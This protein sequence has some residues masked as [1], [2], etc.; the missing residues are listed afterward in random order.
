MATKALELNVEFKEKVKDGVTG[1]FSVQP[2]E[3]GYGTTIGNA[4]R[5]VLMTAIPGA[6]ITHIKIEGVQHEFSTISGVK[7]DVADIIM[8]LKNVRFRLMDNKPD[9][10]SIK[11]KG[12]KSFTA[13]DIQ[14]ASDKYDQAEIFH[15]KGLALEPQNIHALY[16]LAHTYSKT[17]QQNEE[18]ALL[19]KIQRM[20]PGTAGP[21]L[22]LREIY[23]KQKDWK[24]VCPLQKK[25]LPLLRDKN[26]EWKKEQA[27]L[28]QFFFELGKQ[29]LQE[30]NL[31]SAISTF[32][33]ALRASEQCLPAYLS[34]GDAYLE[35]GKQKQ[36]LKIWKT[37]FQK[38]GHKACL[39]RSQ[40]AL[41][42]SDDFQE[43]L[44][45]YEESLETSEGR[46]LLVL[47]LSTFYLEHGL[48]D[49]ARQL[50]QNNSPEHPLLHS[51]LLENAQHSGNGT[52]GTS[53][54]KSHFELTRN[55]VFALT[56]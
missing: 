4:M 42:E 18:I 21:L 17:D 15:K 8:N 51:L 32:K 50:L 44:H 22:R 47:L 11:L 20:N 12:K 46:S 30:G 10:V 37:G 24:K 35:S 3:R 33:Q 43:L 56:H 14:D 9:K 2:L 39:V 41:R 45:T 6:A 25:V 31:D 55:A 54:Q 40:I 28:G 36:A 52:N 34:L 38:T 19:Q 16:D 29:Y 26:E 1:S 27:N 48:E 5:R 13:Q 49:K 23:V 7:E 53:S